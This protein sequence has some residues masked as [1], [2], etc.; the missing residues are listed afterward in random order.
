MRLQLIKK[1]WIYGATVIVILTVLAFFTTA[2]PLNSKYSG[3]S[4]I[5]VLLFALPSYYGLVKTYA[6]KQALLCIVVMSTFALVLENLAVVTGFPYGK[7]EYGALIGKTLGFVPWTVGFGWTPIL[8]GA[9]SLTQRLFPQRSILL[10]VLSSAVLM[11]LF[12][13][14]LDPGS[15]A[16]GFW[17]WQHPGNFYQV[18]WSNFIGWLVSSFFGTFLFS[19]LL[20]ASLKNNTDTSPWMYSS[21]LLMLI[22]WTAIAGFKGLWGACLIGGVL[23]ISLL[24][25]SFKPYLTNVNY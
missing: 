21:Y 5:F 3:V 2:F 9:Y 19:K 22:Y 20:K 11:M 7:F 16:L 14:T 15:V 24:I 12:D 25:T 10:K 6:Y 17:T 23:L 4:S 13:I 1:Q 18:P 8:F